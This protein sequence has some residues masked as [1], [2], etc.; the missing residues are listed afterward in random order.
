MV[1][2]NAASPKGESH[3]QEPGSQSHNIDW[4]EKK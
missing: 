3:Q 2:G 4:R 1:G